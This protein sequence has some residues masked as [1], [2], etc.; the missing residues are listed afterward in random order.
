MGAGRLMMQRIVCRARVQSWM[1]L[2]AY[3]MNLGVTYGSLTGAF[4]KTNTKLSEKYQTLV[5]PAGYAFSIWGPI[6]I[7]EGVFAVAQMFP[8]LGSSAVVETM[9]PWWICACCF[10]VAWTVFFAQEIIPVS[11]AC[12]LGILLSLLIGILRT[13]YLP[14][15]SVKEYFLLRV[16]L[17]TIAVLVALFALAAPRA[18]PIIA[19]VACWALLGI[20]VE[21]S[22]PENLMNLGK[23]N[24]IDWPDLIINA[25]Q[26]T[27]LVLSLASGCETMHF[28]VMSQ[29]EH[30]DD[31]TM[32]DVQA[33]TWGT[34]EEAANAVASLDQILTS[35]GIRSRFVAAGIVQP[36]VSLLSDGSMDTRCKIRLLGCL[37]ADQDVAEM[38]MDAALPRLRQLLQ[39]SDEN[40]KWR[41]LMNFEATKCP[42]DVVPAVDGEGLL[43]QGKFDCKAEA[44]NAIG[45]LAN[46]TDRRLFKKIAMHLLESDI[47]EPLLAL[48]LRS[49]GGS[50]SSHASRTLCVLAS[51][52]KTGTVIL[53]KGA[54]KPLV[55]LLKG[56]PQL[57][58]VL[59]VAK[60]LQALA[61]FNRGSMDLALSQESSQQLMSPSCSGTTPAFHRPTLN[62]I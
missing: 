54:L 1:S 43:Q 12:M 42:S 2:V 41:M 26:Q 35:E 46:A 4:G 23:F 10:Q 11:L 28:K 3:A 39:D 17:C 55:S 20:F 52:E 16:S 33:M 61:D 14:D 21:L 15:I 30:K 36:L 25:V 9:T 58:R 51:T 57:A 37:A 56:H 44:A 27:A 48:W 7:W 29:E 59:R 38:V 40:A 18:D 47:L 31:E 13:D 5:T 22:D 49:S 24:F 34:A 6:F 62:I 50:C 53:A 60:V 19:L 32:L 45:E 8:T